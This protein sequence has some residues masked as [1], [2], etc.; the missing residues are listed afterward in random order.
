MKLKLAHEF[1]IQ[2][3]KLEA[4]E[5]EAIR[6]AEEKARISEQEAKERE[7]ER[8]V[9]N[10]AEK[11]AEKGIWETVKSFVKENIPAILTGVGGWLA[12]K[13]R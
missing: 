3:L 4:E 12:S 13:I 8:I 11:E 1:E 9:S 5:K 7:R 6:K 2:K 10:T